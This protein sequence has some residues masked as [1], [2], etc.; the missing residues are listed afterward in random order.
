[1]FGSD[2]GLF[3]DYFLLFRSHSELYSHVSQNASP[4]AGSDQGDTQWQGV[5]RQKEIHKNFH[6]LSSQLPFSFLLHKPTQTCEDFEFDRFSNEK[7][8]LDFECLPAV[9]KAHYLDNCLCSTNSLLFAPFVS[10]DDTGT[11]TLNKLL[12][13]RPEEGK[14]E[15]SEILLHI[16][17]AIYFLYNNIG[18]IRAIAPIFVDDRSA[19]SDDFPFSMINA[20]S[21]TPSTK[22]IERAKVIIQKM[23]IYNDKHFQVIADISVKDAIVILLPPQERESCQSEYAFTLPMMDLRTSF[24]V[25]K[26]S[27]SSFAWHAATFL[28]ETVKVVWDKKSLK[29]QSD[30]TMHRPRSSEMIEWLRSVGLLE[31][32]RQIL[33]LMGISSLQQLRSAIDLDLHDFVRLH[34]CV[35]YELPDSNSVQLIKQSMDALKQ[36]V[37]LARSEMRFQSL[38]SRL[39][40]YRDIEANQW[41]A[42]MTSNAIETGLL[43]S[44]TQIIISGVSMIYLIFASYEIQGLTG[45]RR[46]LY[47][48]DNNV[49]V[50]PK[51]LRWSV[52]ADPAISIFWAIGYIVGIMAARRNTPLNGGRI[53]ISTAWL[54]SFMYVVC[55]M[56]DF[57]QCEFQGNGIGSVCHGYWSLST[58]AF[59]WVGLFFAHV[60]QQYFYVVL[61]FLQGAYCLYFTTFAQNAQWAIYLFYVFGTMLL[62]FTISMPVMYY[63]KLRAIYEELEEKSNA[64]SEAWNRMRRNE[65]DML[66]RLYQLTRQVNSL[67]LVARQTERRGLGRKAMILMGLYK[68]RIS[69]RLKMGQRSND[70][71]LLYKEAQQLSG[72]FQDFV[73]RWNAHGVVKQGNIKTCSRALQ[74][75]VRSYERDCS[76]L[77]DLVRCSIVVK[78]LTELTRWVEHLMRTSEV[79]FGYEKRFP[80]RG[81]VQPDGAEESEGEGVELSKKFMSITCIKN[82]YDPA[83]NKHETVGYR[84]VCVCVEV[85]YIKSSIMNSCMLVPLSEWETT[86]GLHRHICEMQVILHDMYSLKSG[87]HKSYVQF[88]NTVVQ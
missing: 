44:P 16:I 43:Q 74:K 26:G 56:L 54:V 19:G 87:L 8:Y 47:Q 51:V 69:K 48:A 29:I 3:T 80:H 73:A 36:S 77:T 84:D 83:Y 35:E 17:L 18:W 72:P 57:I 34:S 6:M 31:D 68:P 30:F 45:T 9:S 20:L 40:R 82:R 60:R 50:E 79:A 78:D 49:P 85:G 27:D 76:K 39:E 81:K 55:A 58:S 13:I 67:L 86:E 32:L 38:K 10:L 46:W 1:V 88:R 25:L 4:S 59:I 42:M 37:T 41:L 62:V 52:L 24:L 64:F 14:D 21:Q 7:T 2:F 23:G 33:A 11:G 65:A 12:S 22:T 71:E 63:L 28:M 66:Q 5:Q 70:I 15:S 75:V 61:C 53:L